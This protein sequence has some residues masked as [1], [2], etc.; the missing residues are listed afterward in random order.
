MTLVSCSPGEPEVTVNFAA[1]DDG[2]WP[3][4][5]ALLDR[6]AGVLLTCEDGV[7]QVSGR[8]DSQDAAGAAGR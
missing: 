1:P 8:V 7:L 2:R 6:P 5:A 4:R 3:V